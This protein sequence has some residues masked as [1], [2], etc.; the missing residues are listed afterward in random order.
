MG[1]ELVEHGDL[2]VQR[3]YEVWRTACDPQNE[4]SERVLKNHLPKQLLFIGNELRK[5]SNQEQTSEMWKL[6]SRLEPEERVLQE[7]PIEELVHSYQVV[8]TTVRDWIEERGLAVKFDE[9]TYFY[10][11]IF[12]LTAESVRRYSKFQAERV[13]RERG[14]Y[15]AA[16]AHQMRTPLS[17]L[18]G[19]TDLLESG[20]ATLNPETVDRLRRSI[21]RLLLLTNG[22]MRLERFE[23]DEIPV[24]PESLS[25]FEL[26]EEIMSDHRYDAE[27]KGLKLDNLIDPNLRMKL[28]PDLFIDAFGNLIQNSVKY[29]SSG[30]VRVE[31]SVNSS[32]VTFTITDSGQ[33]ISRKRQKELFQPIIGEKSGG[34]GLGLVIVH[35]AVIAQ[36]GI[37]GVESQ[38]GGGTTFWIRLPREVAPRHVQLINNE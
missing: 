6:E 5:A 25:P 24:R 8:V 2:I 17:V 35:R 21:N 28:D 1:K 16:I 4:L 14:D 36:Q 33:G 3:W 20:F 22:V 7:I 11:A 26:V 23:I 13:R 10:K 31:A 30:F 27:R 15:L 19:Q 29:V 9:F 34:V 12:E 18:S 37:V 38:S 32:E